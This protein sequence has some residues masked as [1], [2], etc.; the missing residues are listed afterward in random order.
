MTNDNVVRYQIEGISASIMKLSESQMNICS[1]QIVPTGISIPCTLRHFFEW[2]KAAP[3]AKRLQMSIE[4][5]WVSFQWDF[6]LAEFNYN[7]MMEERKASEN[8][9]I[10][11]VARSESC[12]EQNEVIRVESD[13]EIHLGVLCKFM[14]IVPLVLRMTSDGG[15]NM[16]TSKL[17]LRC[18]RN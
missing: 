8:L 11:L 5:Q 2:S 4:L 9:I 3:F 15:F 13:D 1:H 6:G 16:I 7:L 18:W 12:W 14:Q 10:Y 17:S